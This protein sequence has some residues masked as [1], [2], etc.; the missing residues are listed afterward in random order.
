MFLLKLFIPLEITCQRLFICFW[1]VIHYKLNKC[2]TDG[3]SIDTE[4]TSQQQEGLSQDVDIHLDTEH[5]GHAW[6]ET[7][8]TPENR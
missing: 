5:K 6:T 3:G 1:S 2:L 7:T 4:F 8:E